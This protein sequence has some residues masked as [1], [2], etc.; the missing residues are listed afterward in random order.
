MLVVFLGGSVVK[1][2]PVMQETQV[3]PLGQEDPLEKEMATHSSILAWRT[4]WTEEP[5]GSQRVRHN[6]VTKHSLIQITTFLKLGKTGQWE[7]MHSRVHSCT[8]MLG[9]EVYMYMCVCIYIYIYSML[10]CPW[11]SPGKNIGMGCHSLPQGSS[12]PRDW[13]FYVSCIGRWVLYY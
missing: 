9:D 1:N 13:T 2:L 8:K 3:Q 11:N 7:K 5:G 4:Q 6:W 12:W 10:L